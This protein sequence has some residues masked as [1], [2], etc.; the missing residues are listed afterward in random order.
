MPPKIS[1]NTKKRLKEIATLQKQA[2]KCMKERK[3]KTQKRDKY[4]EKNNS[5]YVSLS[6]RYANYWDDHSHATEG[7]K[8]KAKLAKEMDKVSAKI[9][10]IENKREE[11]D[12]EV[13]MCDRK[14]TSLYD[15][16]HNL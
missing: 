3:R 6:V 2:D 16:L 8:T 14:C 15:K 4:Y 9:S 12:A 1:P 10:K 5:K 7:T 13:E 11:L